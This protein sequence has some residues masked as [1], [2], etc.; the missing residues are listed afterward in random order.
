MVSNKKP[1]RQAPKAPRWKKV[2]LWTGVMLLVL[3]LA[4]IV[5]FFS[6]YAVTKVPE[7]QELKTNQ[8]AT[9]YASDS[10]TQLARIVPPDGNR[11]DVDLSAVP[12]PVRQAVL[13]AEDRTFYS[14]PGFSVKGFGRAAVGLVTGKES[15][16]DGST[17]TQQY[18]KNALVGNEH[19]YTRKAKE[20][21][22]SAKMAREWSKDEILG[23]YLN[24]IYFGRNAYGIAAAAKA[25]FNKDVSDLTPEEG[26]V[27]AAAIQRPSQ[28]DPWTN[29]PAAQERW[30]YV[31]DGMKD[32]GAISGQER[33]TAVYPEVIDPNT[34]DTSS[35]VQGTNGLIKSQ[36]MA[37]LEASGIS[38]Q[39]VNTQGL[40]ITTTIDPKVQR[41]VTDTVNNRMKNYP[42]DYRTA[43][44]SVDPRNG[45]V[46]GYYGGN[47]PNGWDFANTGLQTGSTF[48]I[49]G[50]AAGLEQ[51]MS[52]SRVYSSAPVTIDNLTIQNS[53]GQ[54]CGSCSL[55]TALKM[56]LN[57]SFVRMQHDLKHGA[58]DTADMAHRLGIPT[59]ANGVKTLQ[60]KN[61]QVYDGVILGQYLTRPLDMATGLSTLAGNGKYHQTHF[62]HKVETSS[63]KVLLDRSKVEGDQRIDKDVANNV[64]SAMEPI[65]AHSRGHA[66]AGGRTS[67]AKSGTAQLG[68]TGNNKDAWFIGATPQLA[69]AVW[70]G[71]HDGKPIFY[72]GRPMYGSGLPADMW[73]ETMDNALRGEEFMAFDES[74]S[75]AS[76]KGG[77]SGET[78]RTY[79]PTT[80]RQE[81]PPTP[82]STTPSPQVPEFQSPSVTPQVPRPQPNPIPSPLGPGTG[83]GNI[84]TRTRE[85]IPGV[86][87]PVPDIGDNGRRPPAP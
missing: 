46:K 35:D 69:T 53:E 8:I 41:S 87:I 66:L 76:K 14:N 86:E 44:V 21:V 82:V 31:M 10:S 18:V 4:P 72:S 33:A 83:G 45:G 55:A 1:Q 48:K 58:K 7:P 85:I 2:L 37:E 15:S 43:I 84:P 49:F 25:Y 6:A 26:A 3:I 59:D 73:K 52:L 70:V 24:T 60:E 38:E 62:V 17:I 81:A 74:G 71:T 32:M 65:A 13:A 16:G 80:T 51:G 77:N 9:I 68:D 61:G 30:N 5:A 78:K 28:L 19:S 12:Q 29:R 11:T 22:I 54:S 47:D 63:G 23:A 56:S 50:L 75:S 36:V 42:D 79:A 27:L 40:K 67:A 39:D 64:I 20:L 34:V 57:T